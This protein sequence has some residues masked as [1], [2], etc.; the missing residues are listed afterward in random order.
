[1][2][3][4][5]TILIYLETNDCNCA[6]HEVHTIL[7]KATEISIRIIRQYQLMRIQNIIIII[8]FGRPH[9]HHNRWIIVIVS[10]SVTLIKHI[11]AV[12]HI[13]WSRVIM[14]WG[15]VIK[16]IRCDCQGLE[17]QHLKIFNRRVGLNLYSTFI[18][19]KQ[20]Y[21]S[22]GHHYFDTHQLVAFLMIPRMQKAF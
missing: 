7:M 20:R 12:V 1:M 8:T 19:H 15:V 9:R 22:I 10:K 4:A 5:N 6:R 13:H 17:S 21:D 2:A 14:Y 11:E 18:L 3:W 16:I